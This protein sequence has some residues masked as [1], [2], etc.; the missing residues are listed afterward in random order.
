M[1]QLYGAIQ[2]IDHLIE[3]KG[4][5]DF[6]TKGQIAM[7]AGFYLS[8]IMPSTEDDDHRLSMLRQAAEKVLGETMPF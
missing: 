3:K 4:L 7:E 2:T 5:D 1:G 8:V 6:K